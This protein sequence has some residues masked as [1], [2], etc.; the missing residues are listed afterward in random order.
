MF[1]HQQPNQQPRHA[2]VFTFSV[3]SMVY[4]PTIASW[5]DLENAVDPLIQRLLDGDTASVPRLGRKI[6]RASYRVIGPRA[7]PTAAPSQSSG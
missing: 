2:S 4:P 5:D 1:Q 7:G 6:D 3:K